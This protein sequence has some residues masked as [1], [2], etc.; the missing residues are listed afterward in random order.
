MYVL[1]VYRL[2]ILYVF[3]NFFFLLFIR[4][5]SSVFLFKT[6][7]KFIC[8][9]KRMPSSPVDIPYQSCIKMVK[10]ENLNSYGL[11]KLICVA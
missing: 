10:F 5:I 3:F 2:H 9:Q 4:I 1:V 7:T 11:Q 6:G 8:F